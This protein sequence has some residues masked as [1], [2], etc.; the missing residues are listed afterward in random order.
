MEPSADAYESPSPSGPAEPGFAGGGRWRTVLAWTVAGS[1]GAW[2]VV[3]LT[4]ADR[5]IG[6]PVVPLLSFTPYV[7]AAAPVPV[8]GAVLL[9]RWRAAAV[10]GVVAAGL[11]AAVLPR[12][13]PS[14]Q[15]AAQGPVLRVLST[16]LLFSQADPA[17]VVALARRT[18]ADVL[19]VQE[20]TE[21][22]VA[23]LAR[24]GLT[25]LLPYQ[26]LDPREGPA[27]SGIYARHPLRALPPVPGT[28]MAMPQAELSLPGGVRVEVTAVHPLPPLSTVNSAD[29]QHDLAALPAADHSGPPRVLV[30]DYNATLDHARFRTL[31][32]R[33][34]ADAADQAGKGLIPTWGVRQPAPPITIDHVVVDRRVAV[35]RVEVYALPG[36]D[37]R[38]LFA[39]L[40]LP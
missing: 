14:G 6:V 28:A 30:G 15:P 4:G 19:S 20:L 26:V 12:A 38:A 3:R 31:L 16:N 21:G 32:G 5:V 1:W 8:I 33:G 25:R 27:G 24:A 34:Y 2:A 9:R 40:R 17:A 13:F 39:E 7:A 22:G 35:R 23:A 29:W 36:S 37:H 10:A 18:G 11:L